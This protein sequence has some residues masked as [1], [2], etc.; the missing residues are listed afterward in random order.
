MGKRIDVFLPVG[1]VILVVGVQGRHKKHDRHS[2]DQT[3]DY[4]HNLIVTFMVI[5]MSS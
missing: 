1:T 4:M 3:L 2:I 5:L